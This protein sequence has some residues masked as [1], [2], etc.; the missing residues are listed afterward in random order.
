MSKP[1]QT[2]LFFAEGDKLEV[3]IPEPEAEERTFKIGDKVT[4]NPDYS[5][6]KGVFEVD[7]ILLDWRKPIYILVNEIEEAGKTVRLFSSAMAMEL[8]R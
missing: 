7:S 8:V 1:T 5:N 3:K 6:V 4:F 2:K